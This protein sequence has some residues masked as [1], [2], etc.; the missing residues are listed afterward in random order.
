MNLRQRKKWDKSHRTF[1]LLEVGETLNLIMI[2]KVRG[3][4]LSK[5][6]KRFVE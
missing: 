5:K 6:E 1:G 4:K 3:E 2:K